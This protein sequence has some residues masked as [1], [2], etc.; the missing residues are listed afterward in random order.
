MSIPTLR[1]YD[2]GGGGA[3]TVGAVTVGAMVDVDVY[4]MNTHTYI[5]QLM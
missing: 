1:A 3:V 4:A 2:S 5:A